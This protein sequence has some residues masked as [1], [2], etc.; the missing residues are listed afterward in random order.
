MVRFCK[1]TAGNAVV[2]PAPPK[3]MS[4]TGAAHQVPLVTVIR[5]FSVSTFAPIV[6]RAAGQGER[7]AKGRAVVQRDAVDIVNGQ[8]AQRGHA[9]RN[10]HARRA[11][12]TA[13][14][15]ERGRRCGSQIARRAGN[16]RAVQR[17]HLNSIRFGLNID[18]G[19]I[20]LSPLHVGIGKGAISGD[21][22]LTPDKATFDADVNVQAEHLDISRLLASA[23]LGSE[24]GE[25]M[26]PPGSRGGA[27]PLERDSGG[28][29]WRDSSDHASGRRR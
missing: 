1:V 5:P 15:D 6:E 4:E 7:A 12:R 20:K 27:L 28:R 23:G 11:R 26:E 2:A 3:I 9:A 29:Q 24:A 17:H 19:G 22:D 13:A 8:S 16:R 21:V 10:V 18:D 14:K 25:L